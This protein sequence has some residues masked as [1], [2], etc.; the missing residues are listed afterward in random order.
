LVHP[1]HDS[2]SS[3]TPFLKWLQQVSTF[4]IHPCIKSISTIFA[5]LYSFHLPSPSHCYP[6]F[7]M[8]Y[9]YSHPSLFRHLFIVQ[10]GFC[11]G[12]LHINILYFSQFNC[13]YYSSLPFPTTLYCS[14][15]IHIFKL[16]E[17]CKLR[18]SYIWETSWSDIYLFIMYLFTHSFI[19]FLS[20]P[21][22]ISNFSQVNNYPNI[23]YVSSMANAC[24]SRALFFLSIKWEWH[25]SN[26]DAIIGT[27][28][29]AQ[30]QNITSTK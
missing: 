16:A 5:L 13:L 20:V 11:L 14:I 3:P 15:A 19:Q 23:Q 30:F 2:P 4:Y 10:W 28:Y 12:T 18:W 8:T 29:T 26:Q 27:K 24:T 9:L 21:F 25:L 7:N 17:F 22:I 6:P 1:L